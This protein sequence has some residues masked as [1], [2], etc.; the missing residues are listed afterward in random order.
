MQIDADVSM[1]IIRFIPEVVWHAGIRTI[2]LER[3]YDTVLECFDYSSGRPLVIPKLRDMTYLSARALVHL[4]IQP[5]C[6][7]NDS[8]GAVFKS[9]SG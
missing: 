8:D 5:K 9:I 7:G 4:A 2:P 3:L 6:I 1:A